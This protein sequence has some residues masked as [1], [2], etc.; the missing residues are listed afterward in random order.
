MSTK[1]FEDD[2]DFPQNN[3]SSPFISQPVKSDDA[4]ETEDIITPSS[5]EEHIIK[6]ENVTTDIAMQGALESPGNKEQT[7]G[8]ILIEHDSRQEPGSEQ[9][10]VE[11]D[12]LP[13][14]PDV[15]P[16]LPSDSPPPPPPLPPS[17]PP[18]TPPPPPPLPLSPASPPPPPPPPPPLPSGPPPQPAPP[19]LP[20]QAPPLPS[21]P[22]PVASSP[23][24]L[25]YQPPA[26][27]YFRT[28]NVIIFLTC[29]S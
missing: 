3:G 14:V 27:E 2:E 23:T 6:P 12:E 19:P 22:P 21:I 24:S 8:A 5:V 9:A 26:P 13:P 17:P 20:T 25:G 18:A 15:F 11:Q 29:I 1:V 7:D 4:R 10:L 16:P 28:S